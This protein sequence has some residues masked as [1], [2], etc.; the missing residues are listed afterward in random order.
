MAALGACA[1]VFE[2]DRV[3]DT[4]HTR[5]TPC[6]LNLT[7]DPL[8]ATRHRQRRHEHRHMEEQHRAEREPHAGRCR[9]GLP[10]PASWKGP[11][12]QAWLRAATRSTTRA[13]GPPAASGRGVVLEQSSSP[14]G[15]HAATRRPV[16]ASAAAP[17]RNRAMWMG[18]WRVCP[19]CRRARSPGLPWLRGEP[20]RSPGTLC[21]CAYPLLFDRGHRR[22]QRDRRVWSAAKD[23]AYEP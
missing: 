15:I 13:D 20:E 6:R 17:A 23:A 5:A 10:T 4:V 2:G 16:A 11:H 19:T 14:K 1:G 8:I 21:T 3:V 18:R 12:G 7:L 22:A 9:R